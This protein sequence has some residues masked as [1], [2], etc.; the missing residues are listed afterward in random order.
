MGA[1]VRVLQMVGV[2]I[3]T[4]ICRRKGLQSIAAHSLPKAVF[5]CAAPPG[6]GAA[7][8]KVQVVRPFHMDI[9]DVLRDIFDLRL[10]EQGTE[11]LRRNIGQNFKTAPQGQPGV[12]V[13]LGTLVA[14][15]V[16]AVVL[17][18][19]VKAVCCLLD[20]SLPLLLGGGQQKD[21]EQHILGAPACPVA[22]RLRAV[23]HPPEVAC[24]IG[25]QDAG[26][27]RPLHPRRE[28]RRSGVQLVGQQVSCQRQQGAGLGGKQLHD[29]AGGVRQGQLGGVPHIAV[30]GGQLPCT[31]FTERPYGI[32]NGI[33]KAP[34]VLHALGT[35][36]PAQPR[37]AGEISRL[38]WGTLPGAGEIQPERERQGRNGRLQRGFSRLQKALLCPQGQPLPCGAFLGRG[39]G[40]VIGKKFRQKS[41]LFLYHK[42]LRF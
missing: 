38:P 2:G 35:Y 40:P 4:E 36:Q 6:Q 11:G 24:K 12:A 33:Q 30:V 16:R 14:A 26:I 1:A 29:G 37:P 21:R 9:A 17:Q 23:A 25:R 41:K 31:F 5:P 27:Q 39:E 19:A 3:G 32:C 22:H 28:A 13:I 42:S 20:G 18:K 34:F 15:A 10:M 8:P 7:I